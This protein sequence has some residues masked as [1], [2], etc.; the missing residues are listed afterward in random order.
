MYLKRTG[1]PN[2]F[3]L[4]F[5][6]EVSFTEKRSLS[7]A[8]TTHY[9]SFINEQQIFFISHSSFLLK[10]NDTNILDSFYMNQLQKK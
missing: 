4:F 9:Q 2:F 8:Y 10:D 6:F 7:Y 3:I 5:G 1:K